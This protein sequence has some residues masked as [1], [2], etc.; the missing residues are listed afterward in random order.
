MEACEYFFTVYE[1]M[2][3]EYS[4]MKAEQAAPVS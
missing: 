3:K 2:Y 4:E 1:R